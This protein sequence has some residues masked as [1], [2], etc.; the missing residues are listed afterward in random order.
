MTRNTIT[1]RRFLEI[2]ASTGLLLRATLLQSIVARADTFADSSEIDN[3][4]FVVVRY[5]GQYALQ[6]R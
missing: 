4:V 2:A 5:S 6:G 1:R 3:D